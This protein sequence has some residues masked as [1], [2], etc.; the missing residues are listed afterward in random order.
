MNRIIYIVSS[1][2]NEGSIAVNGPEKRVFRMVSS[3]ELDD[4]RVEVVYP[5]YGKLIFPNL[6]NLRIHISGI[7]HKYDFRFWLFLFKS[8]QNWDGRTVI[9]VQGPPSLDFIAVIF[10]LLKGYRVIVTRPLPLYLE[11]YGFF[12][13][14]ILRTLDWI[15]LKLASEIIVQNSQMYKIYVSLYGIRKVNLVYNGVESYPEMR[16]RLS[17][18]NLLKIFYTAQ[19][20]DRK[21]HDFII[22]LADYMLQRGFDNFKFHL[23]GG[24]PNFQKI[25]DNIAYRNLN[26]HIVL[27]G[28]QSD[29][30]SLY[31]GLSIYF[32]PSLQEGM[33]VACLEALSVGMPIVAF[34][35]GG[36]QDIIQHGESGFIITR[37]EK[38]D[39][40]LK[41]LC[42]NYF[43]ALSEVHLNL[44]FSQ[45]TIL[46]FEKHFTFQ[47]YLKSY[48][49][50]YEK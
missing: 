12:M 31:N 48:R 40:N 21:N 2:R 19:F 33:S 20:V 26:E 35:A 11:Q 5:D 29:P 1:P 23:V 3:G 24:G 30:R 17:S 37:S 42:F 27:N 44:E 41:E 39:D 49:Y 4:F 36:M 6:K 10:G 34:D 47:S 45:K 9:H 28:F 14:F 15:S 13:K 32:S 50:F 25:A 43:L 18:S 16:S 46:H 7:K 8:I 38:V 22:D